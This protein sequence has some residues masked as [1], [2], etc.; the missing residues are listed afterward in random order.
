MVALHIVCLISFV[1]VMCLL[2]K[3]NMWVCT[4][5]SKTENTNGAQKDK[6]KDITTF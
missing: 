5:F 3:G 2:L 1:H 4:K 6:K